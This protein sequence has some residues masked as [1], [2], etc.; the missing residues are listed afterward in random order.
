[1]RREVDVEKRLELITRGAEEVVTLDELRR[2]LE[3]G[4]KLRGYLGYEPSGLFHIGWMIWAEKVKELVEAGVEFILLEATWHAWIND[5][6]GGDIETIRKAAEYIRHSLRALG[7]PVDRIRFVQAEELVSDPDYWALLLKVSKNTTLARAKRALTIMG[8]RADEAELDSSKI[9]YPFMQVTDIFKLGVNIAVGGMDQRR[10]HM[11]AR[12]VAEKL[13]LPKPTA[14]HTPLL[15]SLA[16]IGRAGGGG[17]REIDADTIIEVKMS[18]SKP[19]T[20]ILIHD[21]PN[22]IKEKIRRAYCPP[23]E[24]S[25]NPIIEIN[26]HILFRKPGFTLF[27]KRPPKYGGDLEITSYEELEKLYVEGKLHPADLKAATAEA[28]SELLEPVR[29]YFRKN[30]KARK[31]ALEIARAQGVELSLE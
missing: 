10:A 4:G 2:K 18:K 5:K 9:I 16:G 30:D 13:G 27:V 11:L 23:R 3:E 17:L 12:D 24:T 22:L 15:T 29:E 1:M 7:V 14:L 26:K 19:E 28:L 25:L 31:L 21:P 20:T 6:F 8:R